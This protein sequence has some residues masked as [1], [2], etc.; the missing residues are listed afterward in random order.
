MIE[1][2]LIKLSAAV[3]FYYKEDDISPGVVIS[4][5]KDKQIYGSVV[6]YG[7]NWK[8]GKVI[9]CNV[10]TPSLQETIALL[11]KRFVEVVS[12]KESTTNPLELL[13]KSIIYR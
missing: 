4:T 10:R 12:E 8:N 7:K 3:S 5:L 1:D 11:S 2:L 13:K 6:R 9:I